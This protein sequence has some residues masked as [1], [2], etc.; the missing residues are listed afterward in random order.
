MQTRLELE[1]TTNAQL[2]RESYSELLGEL[3]NNSAA[4][5]RDEIALASQEM[6]EKVASLKSGI[7]ILSAAAV[8]GLIALETLTAAAV[9]GLI[10]AVGAANAALIVGSAL[11][12]IGAAL[13][14]VGL[15]R[16]KRTSLRPEQTIETLEEDKIWL[17]EL[18]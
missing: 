10:Q 13:A 18:T 9:I 3:A 15:G 12:V 1:R 17:K 11:A 5:V 6:R 16:I 7:L 4:L 14:L 8:I 2:P